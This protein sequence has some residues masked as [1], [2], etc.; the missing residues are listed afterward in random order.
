MKYLKMVA[1]P[2]PPIQFWTIAP[3]ECQKSVVKYSKEKPILLNFYHYYF[4]KFCVQYF[5]HDCSNNKTPFPMLLFDTAK[6]NVKE[7]Y[8]VV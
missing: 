2:Q 3:K 4:T 8:Q 1:S 5:V 7:L 6:E